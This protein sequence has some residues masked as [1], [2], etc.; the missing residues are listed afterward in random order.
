MNSYERIRELALVSIGRAC[1][2]GMLAIATFMFALLAWPGLAMR[3]G[4]VMFLVTSAI[5]MLKAAQAPMRNYRRTEV[6]LLLGKQHDLPEPR[7]QAIFGEV[8]RSTY[9][10]FAKVT[11]AAA[12]VLW[13]ADVLIRLTGIAPQ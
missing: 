1:L 10:Q 12:V 7:A 4:A 8:L 6:W 5:L 3:S 11:A 9:V 2:F 13:L